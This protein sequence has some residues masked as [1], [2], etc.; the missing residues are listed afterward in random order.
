MKMRLFK[1]SPWLATMA[2]TVAAII[3]V[4]LFRYSRND[5]IWDVGQ[6]FEAVSTGLQ[7]GP[8]YPPVFAYWISGTGGEVRKVLRLLKAVYHPRNHYLLHLDAGSS[9]SERTELAQLVQSEKIFASFRNVDVVGKTYVVDRTGPSAVAATLHGAAVLLRINKNWDWLITLSSSDYPL[10]SQDDLLYVFS[11]LPR[12]LNFIDH[13][14]DLG[15]KEYERF[16]KIIVD[17]S[18]YLDR[19]SHSFTAT[20]TRSTPEAF[21][22][23]TGSP[24]MILSRPFLEHCVHSWDN[25][26]RKLLMY[27]TNVAYAMESYFQT[28]ICNSPEFQNT[29]VNND[30]RYFIWDNPPKLDP[31]FLNQSSYKDMI[32]SRAAFARR[33]VEDEPVLRVVDQKILKRPTNG[34]ALGK[35]CSVLSKEQNGENADDQCSSW[36]DINAIKPKKAGKRLKSLVLEL[37]SDQKMHENQCK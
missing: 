16:D 13:T 17:P 34:V 28:V 35:W 5:G 6:E 4:V 1:L 32:K 22:I 12:D 27:F 7:K 25:L 9:V 29:T 3:L 19:N 26:P 30:L 21:K 20:E 18:L 10:V 24:W 37:V 2:F 15:W 8:G 11:S 31:L 33:F 23:F 14:S 36:S